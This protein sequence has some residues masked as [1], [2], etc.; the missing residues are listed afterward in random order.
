MCAPE[1][2]H[3]EGREAVLQ[4]R[5]IGSGSVKGREK[6]TQGPPLAG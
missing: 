5:K 6:G 4:G 3:Q 2:G 1:E